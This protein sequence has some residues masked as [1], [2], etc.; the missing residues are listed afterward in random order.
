MFE[1]ER[2][3]FQGLNVEIIR[4][5]VGILRYRAGIP[6]SREEILRLSVGGILRSRVGTD[7][8]LSMEILN[9]TMGNFDIER[10]SFLRSSLRILK[11]SVGTAKVLSMGNVR[12]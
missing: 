3:K 5:G 11:F 9:S 12:G 1:I 6:R 8:I 4:S 2:G 7:K 10:R